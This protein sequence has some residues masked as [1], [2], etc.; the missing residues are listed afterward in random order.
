MNIHFWIIAKRIGTLNYHINMATTCR[1]PSFTEGVWKECGQ[2]TSCRRAEEAKQG[3]DSTPA[4]QWTRTDTY[5]QWD[6]ELI[7]R[8]PTTLYLLTDNIQS[9]WYTMEKL[10]SYPSPVALLP[11]EINELTTE[12][13]WVID[14]AYARGVLIRP[15]VGFYSTEKY[16]LDL[17]RLFCVANSVFFYRSRIKRFVANIK[18]T[19]EALFNECVHQSVSKEFIDFD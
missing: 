2:C 8:A 16:D 1:T 7:S 14:N 11:V 10:R 3:F 5:H 6:N 9:P 13:R 4:A 15:R 19:N 17:V 18:L 12:Q